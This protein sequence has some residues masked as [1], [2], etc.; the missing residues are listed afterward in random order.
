VVDHLLQGTPTRR[1][2]RDLSLDY[3]APHVWLN[4]LDVLSL[5]LQVGLT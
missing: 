2:Q 3:L 4:E 5:T 1:K